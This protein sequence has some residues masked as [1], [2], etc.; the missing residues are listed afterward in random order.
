MK[1]YARAAGFAAVMAVAVQG[2][3]RAASTPSFDCARAT[4]SAEKAICADARLGALDVSIANQFGKA[5]KAFDAETARAL[6]SEQRQFVRLRDESYE[7]PTDSATG[8]EE[9]AERLRDREAFLTALE[10]APRKGFEGNWGNFSGELKV[11]RLA[12]GRL[13]A[14]V[15]AA[16]PYNASWVCEASGV[17]ALSGDTLVLQEQDGD[18]WTLVLRRV[19]S[20]LGLEEVPP[21]GDKS[22]AS[23]PS[24]GFNGSLAGIYFPL[25]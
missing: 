14:K 20:G 2:G 25:R 10:L 9:I 4:S 3:A 1:R 19:G 24:C 7:H 6:S 15:S 23:S 16:A 13:A 5:R 22:E 11:T 17:G 8:A 12:D 21:P 18:G